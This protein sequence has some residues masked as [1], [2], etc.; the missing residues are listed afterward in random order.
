M[1][2]RYGYGGK[3]PWIEDAFQH[4]EEWTERT[5]E[6]V[7]AAF[8]YPPERSVRPMDWVALVSHVSL[9]R[10]EE[11]TETAERLALYVAAYRERYQKE[12]SPVQVKETQDG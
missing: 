4:A 6:A 9:R 11:P 10:G 2:A 3:V 12:L 8:P 5:L 1:S 7:M